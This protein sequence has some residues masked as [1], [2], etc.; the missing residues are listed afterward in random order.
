MNPALPRTAANQAVLGH[1]DVVKVAVPLRTTITGITSKAPKSTPKKFR[2]LTPS[3]SG[4]VMLK[5][6]VPGT[7]GKNREPGVKIS[8]SRRAYRASK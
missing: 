5:G 8:E 3:P 1:P 2:L 7:V 6:L 4:L